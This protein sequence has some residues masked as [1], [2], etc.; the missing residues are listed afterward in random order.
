[1]CEKKIS[2]LL[3]SPDAPI[4][5]VM[6]FASSGEINVLEEDSSAKGRRSIGE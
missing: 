5:E 1:M 6:E 2:T 3:S 4:Y